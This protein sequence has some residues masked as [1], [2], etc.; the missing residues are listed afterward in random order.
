MDPNPD[1]DASDEVE[2]FFN[3]CRGACA[4]STRPPP[5]RGLTATSARGGNSTT[6]LFSRIGDEHVAVLVDGQARLVTSHVK[7][8]M[9][10][11]SALLAP[12]GIR[13]TD[14]PGVPSRTDVEPRRPR[15]PPPS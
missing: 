6:R 14:V 9:G 8:L 4:A 15:R 13:Y 11:C 5:T 2:Y 1:Y 12:G 3:F 10:S 7:P